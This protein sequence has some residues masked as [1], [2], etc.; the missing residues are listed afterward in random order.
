MRFDLLTIAGL[1]FSFTASSQSLEQYVSSYNSLNN[2]LE[3]RL[4]LKEQASLLAYNEATSEGVGN[5]A[6][7]RRNQLL[8]SEGDKY[9]ALSLKLLKRYCTG[10]DSALVVPSYEN[11]DETTCKF[12]L[13]LN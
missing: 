8:S 2:N 6:V 9:G 3:A 5:D 7:I 4:I 10:D 13:S 1:F 11:P 12:I